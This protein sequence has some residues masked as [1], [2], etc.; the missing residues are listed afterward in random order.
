M[1]RKEAIQLLRALME[2]EDNP[3]YYQALYLAVKA[4]ET[5]EYV[6]VEQ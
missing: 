3:R 4:L 1:T 6:E 2:V 5:M